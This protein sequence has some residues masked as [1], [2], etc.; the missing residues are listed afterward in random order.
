MPS[1]V[2]CGVN[3]GCGCKLT[4]GL[5]ASCLAEQNQ[6]KQPVTPTNQN[7]TVE[8]K[9]NLENASRIHTS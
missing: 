2:K 8:I 5:C 1:C 9:V 6:V 3:V 7:Q 4:N